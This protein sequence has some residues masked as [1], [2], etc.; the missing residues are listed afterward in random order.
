MITF[1]IFLQN[2]LVHAVTRRPQEDLIKEFC[3]FQFMGRFKKG[4]W[5]V[6]KK[7]LNS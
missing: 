7:M 4:T 1:E 3:H 6:L 5:L 2:W